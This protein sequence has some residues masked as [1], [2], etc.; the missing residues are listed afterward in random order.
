RLRQGLA[1]RA[2]AHGFGFRQTGPVTM[3]LFMFEDDPDLR[4]GF[5]WSSAMLARGVY[6]HPWH[7]MFLCA[8]MTTADI[9]QALDA[10]DQAFKT[11]KS[12]APNLPPVEKMAFLA[13]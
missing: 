5:C 7:N 12:A 3:P 13:A 6:V 2:A 1:E 8:A 4:Q 9:D 10:A 11:L